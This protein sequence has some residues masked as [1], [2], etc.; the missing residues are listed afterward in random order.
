MKKEYA[1]ANRR[2][3]IDKASQPGVI[4]L[5]GEL[6]YRPLNT[7]HPSAPSPNRGSVIVFHYVGR[8]INGRTFD[9]SRGATPPAMR[10][11]ELI[12]GLVTAICHMHVGDRWEIYIPASLGY[13][14]SSVPGIPGGSTLIFDIELIN[15]G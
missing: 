10:L 8:T 13:G 3:L 7:P 5:Q 11:R 15:I 1:E 4:K 9:S 2:W 14:K 6:C 12:P